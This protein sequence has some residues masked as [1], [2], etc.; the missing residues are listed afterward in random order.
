M[1][2]AAESGPSEQI[3]SEIL[4]K[5]LE[6]VQEKIAATKD[7]I[8]AQAA[9]FIEGGEILVQYGEYN[10]A[11][12]Y[13]YEAR[14][15]YWMDWSTEESRIARTGVLINIT[16]CYDAMGFSASEEAEPRSVQSS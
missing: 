14:H 2:Q 11:I 15:R 8:I 9:H 3:E 6:V 13:F 5:K 16:A 10:R 1:R 4:Q 7:D 12:E